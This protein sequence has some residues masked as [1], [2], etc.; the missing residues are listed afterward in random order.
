MTLRK[1]FEA[2]HGEEPNKA[3]DEERTR[4]LEAEGYRVIRFWNN[5]IVENPDGVLDVVYAALYGSRDAE[6]RSLKHD[7]K[8]AGT[9]DAAH[10][11]PARVARRPSP[12]R[13]G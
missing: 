6:P 12:S 13:G 8:R 7:R 4:W 1:V 3:R 9:A 2:T 5:D 11:T 10:P